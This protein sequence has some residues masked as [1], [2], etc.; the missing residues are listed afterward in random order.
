MANH[1]LAGALSA[2]EVLDPQDPDFTADDEP[3]LQDLLDFLE[4]DKEDEEVATSQGNFFTASTPS[5]YNGTTAE[6]LKRCNVRHDGGEILYRHGKRTIG[7]ARGGQLDNKYADLIVDLSGTY[8]TRIQ[9]AIRSLESAK[10]FIKSGPE[11]F[12]KLS[13]YVLSSHPDLEEVPDILRLDWQDMRVPPVGLEFWKK[14]WTLLPEG[15]TII[16][17]MGG[18]GRTGTAIASLVIAADPKISSGEAM[19]MVWDRHCEDAIE[20]DGQMDYLRRLA[21]ARPSGDGKDR[22]LDKK[23]RKGKGW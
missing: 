18:H 11:R 12:N 20:T 8:S 10:N 15:H 16:C 17:C 2:G 4:L 19:Q 6:F 14:M 23:G 13:K 5:T 7:G 1:L 3:T 22:A 9:D 21:E